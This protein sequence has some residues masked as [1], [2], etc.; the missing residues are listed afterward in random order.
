MPLCEPMFPNEFS[1]PLM[2]LVS[3]MNHHSPSWTQSPKQTHEI[4]I[5]RAPWDRFS[6][7]WCAPHPDAPQSLGHF[8][9]RQVPWHIFMPN[10]LTFL[11]C[12]T[13]VC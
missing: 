8:I 6:Q 10:V 11:T 13:L 2:D 5:H 9:L 7:P 12:T 1:C 4:V 3:Q